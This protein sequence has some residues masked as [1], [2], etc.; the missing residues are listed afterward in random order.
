MRYKSVMLFL[1][2]LLGWISPL[3]AHEG[4]IEPAH[5]QTDLLRQ[6]QE[7]KFGMFI[8]YG[9]ST[10]TNDWRT[11]KNASPATYAP[12][13]LDVG[14]WVRTARKTGMKYA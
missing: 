1:F 7:L 14:Q 10:F 4:K 5:Q 12:S 13:N 2:A 6:W 8:H 9:L 3:I 11:N